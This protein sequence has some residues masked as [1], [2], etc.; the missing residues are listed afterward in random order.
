LHVIWC[1]A[2]ESRATGDVDDDAASKGAKVEDGL[3]AEVSRRNQVDLQEAAPDSRPGREILVHTTHRVE[4]RVVDH[5]VNAALPGNRLA[6]YPFNVSIAFEIALYHVATRL[7]QI[8]RDCLGG[9]AAAAIVEDDPGTGCARATRDCG[10]DPREAPV[11]RTTF[12]S[13]PGI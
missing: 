5:N 11:T 10:S 12:P 13:R 3:A 6:P 9:F 7:P 2:P 8:A 4:T 1:V